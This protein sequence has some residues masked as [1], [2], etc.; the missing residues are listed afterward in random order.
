HEAEIRVA[1]RTLAERE[2][3]APV[4]Q[5]ALQ[6]DLIACERM[7]DDVVQRPPAGGPLLSDVERAVSAQS[8]AWRDT[9]KDTTT[10]RI[11]GVVDRRLRIEKCRLPALLE[12]D[13]IGRVRCADECRI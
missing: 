7:V 12:Q 1:V 10:D 4:M 11:A 5:I 2:D 9:D 3:R 8:L 6:C 13:R